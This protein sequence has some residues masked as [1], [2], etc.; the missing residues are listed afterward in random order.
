[1]E[2]ARY[3]AA[4]AQRRFLRVDPENRFVADV[5][6][7]DGNARLRELAQ[8]QEEAQLHNEAEQRK[9]SVLERQA[10]ADVVEDFPRVWH[11]PRT[12]DRDRTRMVRLLLEE[13]TLRQDE[14]IPAQIR[15]KG[16]ATH[17][18]TVPISHGR[19]SAPELIALIDQFLDDDTD[20]EVA[21]QRNQRGWRT[22]EGKPVH[23]TR[24]LSFRRSHQ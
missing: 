22:S 10:I 11:D 24:V 3:A 7:A 1:V 6:E 16:G 9:R 12:S 20:A 15:F 14:V 23:A 4:L 13:V 19:C 21:E 5:R 18:M 8:V 2:R 17:T